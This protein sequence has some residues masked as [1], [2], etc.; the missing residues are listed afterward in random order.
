MVHIS[1]EGVRS[2]F[3]FDPPWLVPSYLYDDGR[4][5]ILASFTQLQVKSV[6]SRFLWWIIVPRVVLLPNFPIDR[7]P[8]SEIATACLD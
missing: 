7:S 4:T 8:L 3:G 1:L 5:R 2:D 6:D